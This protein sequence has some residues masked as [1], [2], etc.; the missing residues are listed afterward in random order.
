MNKSENL[1]RIL[2]DGPDKDG[3]VRLITNSSAFVEFG[4]TRDRIMHGIKQASDDYI[5]RTKQYFDFVSIG[6]GKPYC[7]FIGMVE[8]NNGYYLREFSDS[9]Q[10]YFSLNCI[11]TVVDILEKK[12]KSLSP[13]KTGI[14]TKSD[15]TTVI[16]AFSNPDCTNKEF[17]E[18]LY[19]IA[20]NSVRQ[21]FLDLGLTIAHMGPYHSLGSNSKSRE[22]DKEIKDKPLYNSGIPLLIVRRLHKHDHVFMKTEK[23]IAAYEKYFGGIGPGLLEKTLEKT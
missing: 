12:F 3:F 2:V 17:C 7:P 8:G 4:G 18:S 6:N 1:E 9:V 11:Q 14:G 5:F 13:D 19:E 22:N 20:R 23:E 15:M 16:A 21:H 10:N